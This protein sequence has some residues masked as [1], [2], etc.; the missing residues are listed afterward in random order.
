MQTPQTIN[1]YISTFPENIQI[2]LENIRNIIKNSHP[3]L[4]ETINYGV[5]TF[6]INGKN[7]IH[8]GAFKNHISIFPGPKI[9]EIFESKLKNYKTSK[10]AIQFQL[11]Q[12][13]NYE[14]IRDIVNYKISIL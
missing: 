5:P 11:N 6:K 12:N 14:L 7:F 10:G 4:T 3:N 8:F 1:E 9:I 13:I 2:I